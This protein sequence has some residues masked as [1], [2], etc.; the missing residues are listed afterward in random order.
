MSAVSNSIALMIMWGIPSAPL[1][2]ISNESIKDTLDLLDSTG[3]GLLTEGWS[4]AIA[5][6]KNGGL[7]VDSATM[8]GRALLS[9][10]V[11]NVVETMQVTCSSPLIANRLAILK[12][13]GRLARMARA[14]HSTSNQI[15]PVYL[16]WAATCNN[17]L[18]QY[19]LLYNIDWA[20]NGDTLDPM[21]AWDVTLTMEREPYWRMLW[22]GGNPIEC[23]FQMQGKTRGVQSPNEGYTYTNMDL[24][25]NSDHFGFTTLYNL[26]EYNPSDYF[27]ML[28]KNYIDIANV[29]G[30]APA[31][32]QFSI[33]YDENGGDTGRIE[34]LYIGRSTRPKQLRADDGTNRNQVYILNAGDAND[35]GGFT[36]TIDATNGVISNGSSSVKHILQGSLAGLSGF[37]TIANWGATSDTTPELSANMLRG[38]FAVFLRHKQTNGAA[39]D[40]RMRLTVNTGAGSVNEFTSLEVSAMIPITGT[41]MWRVAYMGTMTIPPQDNVLVGG[42]GRGLAVQPNTESDYEVNLQIRNTNAAARTFDAL[43]LILIPLDECSGILKQENQSTGSAITDSFMYDNTGYMRHGKDGVYVGTVFQDQI[44]FVNAQY[45]GQEITLIPGVN[46]RLHFFWTEINGSTI[47]PA[48]VVSGQARE[49]IIRLNIVPRWTGVRDV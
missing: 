23:T 43:D 8:D 21:S 17:G 6:L 41:T 46:N 26:A 36:T 29:P 15:D 37:T 25:S 10:N 44:G 16:K 13:L 33:E 3:L 22:P 7:W 2:P 35:T 47:I 32:V 28:S 30:D 49:T 34:K 48:N 1:D 19:S 42:T 40:I 12:K 24:T 18:E 5:P 11:G 31:L 4:P 20:I 14:F 9:D 27:T 45:L 38:N 39:G